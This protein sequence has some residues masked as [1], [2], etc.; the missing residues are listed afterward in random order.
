MSEPQINPYGAVDLAALAASKNPPAQNADARERGVVMDVTEAEFEQLVQVSNT[1]PV[2]IDLWSPRAEQSKEL[3]PLLEKLALEHDGAFL[4]A[5]VNVDSSPQ[6]AQAFQ[7]QAIPTVVALIQGRPLPLFQGA[8]AEDQLKQVLQEVLKVAQQQGVTGKVPGVGEEPEPE[9]E[10][11]LPPLHQEA[12]DAIER[13]DLPAAAAA[14]EKALAENPGDDLARLGLAQ[15]QLLQRT[16]GVD[17]NDARAAAA[18]DPADIAAQLLVADLDVLGGAIED[19]FLRVLEVVRSTAGAERDQA[20]E[21]LL[22]LFEVVGPD[23]ARVI[24]ARRD[25]T[26]A[27]Y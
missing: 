2:L 11:E 18:A 17:L 10:E 9:A 22:T 12:Y 24:Q 5:K 27:L 7:V 16:R 19:A 15:V 3:S 23:D 20:R 14:Y 8:V 4:H 26:N 1:V 21:H 13:D 6:I 25:L